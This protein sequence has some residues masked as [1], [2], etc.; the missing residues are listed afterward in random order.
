MIK[1]IIKEIQELNH[2]DGKNLLERMVKF[3]EEYGE[4]SAEVCKMQGISHKPFDEPHLKEEM[5]DA[6]QNL[7]SVYLE[8]CELRGFGIDEVFAEILVK[9]KKWREKAPLYTKQKAIMS[10]VDADNRVIQWHDDKKG[11]GQI[12]ITW[13]EEKRGYF[14]DTELL[15]IDSVIEIIKSLK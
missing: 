7:F 15:G 1:L 11:F 9:N 6:M 13:D 2:L 10:S 12:A 8:I 3:N 4:F 14:V 5:A